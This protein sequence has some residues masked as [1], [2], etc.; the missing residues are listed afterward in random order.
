MEP[1]AAEAV[2]GSGDPW[3]TLTLYPTQR[4]DEMAAGVTRTRPPDF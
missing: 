2:D 4:D 3:T 1:D